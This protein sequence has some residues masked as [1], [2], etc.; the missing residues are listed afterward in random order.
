MQSF[1]QHRWFGKHV[2]RQYARDKSKAEALAHPETSAS[3]SLSSS[4]AGVIDNDAVYVVDYAN[5]DTRDPEKGEQ[6]PDPN[7]QEQIRAHDQ[8]NHGAV[9]AEKIAEEEQVESDGFEAI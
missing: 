8:V 6:A 4:S 3:T 1:L 7:P 9:D 5:E 2:K